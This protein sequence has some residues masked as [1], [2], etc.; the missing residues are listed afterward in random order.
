MSTV[1]GYWV[2]ENDLYEC[3]M[4]EHE[5]CGQK[6]LYDVHHIVPGSVYSAGYSLYKV[7][8]KLGYVRVVNELNNETSVA[9]GN[10]V[11]HSKLQKQFIKEA[12]RSEKKDVNGIDLSKLKH[13]KTGV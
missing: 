1:Y 12:T 11:H 13:L 7:M 3:R 2:G 5:D 4:F 9:Y 8:Y 10:N 6:I